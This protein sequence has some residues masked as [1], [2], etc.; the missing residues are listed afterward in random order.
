MSMFRIHLGLL[1]SQPLSSLFGRA[2]WRPLPRHSDSAAAAT[3]GPHGSTS[4]STEWDSPTRTRLSGRP[5]C[6]A[7]ITLVCNGQRMCMRKSRVTMPPADTNSQRL[8]L[9]PVKQ[10]AKTLADPRYLTALERGSRSCTTSAGLQ[11]RGRPAARIA[12]LLVAKQDGGGFQ[13]PV[14]S[15]PTRSSQSELGKSKKRRS[16]SPPPSR[17][18]WSQDRVSLPSDVW[19]GTLPTEKKK[20]ERRGRVA[21]LPASTD[22]RLFSHLHPKTLQHDPAGLAS[23]TLF[24]AGTTVGAGMLALPEVTY[25]AGFVAATA[26]LAASCLFAIITGLLIAEVTINTMRENGGDAVS[27]VTL[28]RNAVGSTGTSVMSAVY[29]F[30]SY[31]LMVAYISR[32]GEVVGGATGT[33]QIASS[34][35]LAFGIAALC[36]FSSSK[37]ISQINGGLVLLF[38]GSL[39]ALLDLVAPGVEPSNLNHASWGDLGPTLPVMFLAFSFQN[40]VPI[41]V[42]DLECDTKKIRAAITAGVSIPLLMFVTWEAVMLGSMPADGSAVV[43]PLIALQLCRSSGRPPGEAMMISCIRLGLGGRQ[44]GQHTRVTGPRSSRGAFVAVRNSTRN[45]AALTPANRAA[46]RRPS[47]GTSAARRRNVRADVGGPVVPTRGEYSP[48]APYGASVRAGRTGAVGRNVG[49]ARRRARSEKVVDDSR[50]ARSGGKSGGS[51]RT[52]F[53]ADL[54][55]IQGDGCHPLAYFTATVPS[56]AL[57]AAFP[58]IFVRVTDPNQL[59]RHFPTPQPQGFVADLLGIQGDGRH[60]LAY[61]IAIVPSV[62]LAAAFPDIFVT[63][64]SVAGTYG[65]MSLFGILPAGMAWIQRYSGIESDVSASKP[66]L[67]PPSQLSLGLDGLSGMARIQRCPGAESDVSTSGSE[68]PISPQLSLG[69]DGLSGMTAT[70]ALL[71]PGGKTLLSVVAGLATVLIAHS[72]VEQFGWL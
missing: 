70:K 20:K 58:D 52:G 65:V 68:L 63:A 1:S 44:G 21:W 41:V 49:A 16:S 67:P 2:L 8:R 31:S 22:D 34:A 30:Y 25:K 55:G 15:S 72:A 43:D 6:Q 18:L 7:V 33:S 17:A 50:E 14:D 54:L 59:N 19:D 23:S 56:V 36:Y 10:A 62:A 60:P 71:V 53:V 24:I 27:L 47:S 29:L 61:F 45:G 12:V 13:P 66:G 57:A 39:F 38:F 28:T 5:L 32:A 26:G 64:L 46:S 35:V 48:G 51:R 4:Q 69:L 11:D 40:T 37:Q 3:S 9:T 42:R